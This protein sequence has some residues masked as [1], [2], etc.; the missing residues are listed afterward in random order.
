M[1]QL[2][3]AE[4]Q[5]LLFRIPVVSRH[6]PCLIPPRSSSA[7]ERLT[8]FRRRDIAP[9]CG[10]ETNRRLRVA[11]QPLALEGVDD[12]SSTFRAAP[13]A[14]GNRRRASDVAPSPARPPG[15]P[16]DQAGENSRQ[17]RHKALTPG[18]STAGVATPF[19][20][21][22]GTSTTVGQVAASWE[23][24]GIFGAQPAGPL[25]SARGT[26]SAR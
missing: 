6:G 8:P 21:L 12:H 18:E 26:S 3:C 5:L 9:S 22:A 13:T 2:L 23:P 16:G 20:R 15:K 1:R 14:V 4:R 25:M 7:P 24:S 10:A 17:K 11:E 19:S